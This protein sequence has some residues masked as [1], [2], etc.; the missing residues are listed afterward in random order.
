MRAGLYCRV[1]QKVGGDVPEKK[2]L[3]GANLHSQ[4]LIEITIVNLSAP[5]DA[6][7]GT[8]HEIVH[9]CGIE[10]IGKQFQIFVPF[11]LF[12][13][14]LRKAAYGLITDREQGGE[15]DPIAVLKFCFVVRLQ[16]GLRWRQFWAQRVVN[17]VE[18]QTGAV[19]D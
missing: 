19:A 6:E 3:T 14:I 18:R 4:H 2:R 5:A 17:Q 9:G 10:A 1:A 7:S 12:A 16:F 15:L 11:S 13:Q 8:A